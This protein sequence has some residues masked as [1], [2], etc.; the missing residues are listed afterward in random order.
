MPTT[1]P[2]PPGAAA[3]PHLF[4]PRGLT[5]RERRRQDLWSF[6]SPKLGRDVQVIGPMAIMQALTFELNPDVHA[7]VERPR[8]I[9]VGATPLELDFWTSEAR[10]LERF[11]LLVPNQ[12]AIE[13]GTPR[14]EHRRAVALI[15]AAQRAH[16]R[17]EFVF[18]H[19]L[20]RRAT[21]IHTA[22]RL[23]P[24]VQTATELPNRDALRDQIR[25]AFCNAER[26]TIDQVCAELRGFPAPDVRAGIADL[27]HAGELA[28]ANPRELTR[29]SVVERRAAH[30][31]R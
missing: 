22:K 21:E 1:L 13:P 26:A 28:L 6:W 31:H 2:R 3:D 25:A 7:Y 9:E 18:E 15:E 23:L 24:Y 20:C 17:L 8:K 27:I 12:D 30:G 5:D 14:R 16:L 10:G 11:W 4:Q 29:F 19:D